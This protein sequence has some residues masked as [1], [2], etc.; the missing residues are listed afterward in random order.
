MRV[1][2]IMAI[3]AAAFGAAGCA[4]V[5]GG[6]AR[7]DGDGAR[8]RFA[9]LKSLEGSWTSAPGSES[10]VA[11]DYRVVGSGSAVHERIFV[12]TPYEMVTMYHM[13]GD[14]LVLTHYCAA[15]N[16]PRMKAVATADPSEVAFRFAG[17]SNGNPSKD[18]HMHD[19][20]LWIGADGRLRSK[21]VGWEGGKPGNHTVE[22]EFVRAQ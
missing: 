9:K 10:P 16:Q 14:D 19:G 4:G 7:L 1:F 6:A 3:T 22:F 12:G 15:G 17:L 13:D 5:G 2:G 8:A 11:L 21:W 20:T 18:M